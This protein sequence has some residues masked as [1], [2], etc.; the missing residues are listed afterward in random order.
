MRVS[1]N[2]LRKS[3]LAASNLNSAEVLPL[4]GQQPLLRWNAMYML[5]T[6]WAMRSSHLE[7]SHTQTKSMVYISMF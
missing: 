3:D 4:K 2:K 5:L 6:N 1:G 7:E